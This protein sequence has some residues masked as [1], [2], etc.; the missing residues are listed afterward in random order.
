MDMDIVVPSHGP[1]GFTVSLERYFV[2]ATLE[3]YVERA[4]DRGFVIRGCERDVAR[5]A[6]L[7]RCSGIVNCSSRKPQR[8]LLKWVPYLIVN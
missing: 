7:K 2:G 4:M 1:V 5:D 6:P 3:L 8:E